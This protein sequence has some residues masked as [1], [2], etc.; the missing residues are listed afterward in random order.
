[1]A[2]T[3]IFFLGATLHA[4][5]TIR[6]LLCLKWARRLPSLKLSAKQPRPKC[7]I[8]FAARDEGARVEQTLRHILALEGVDFEVIPIDDRSR[9]ETSQI[10][11]RIS[12]EDPRVKPKRV[13]VLPENWLGKCHACHLGAQSASGDWLLFTDADCWL[14]P[15]VLTRALALAEAEKSSM[16][17]SH[18]AL[19][20]AHY[21]RKDAT[22]LFFSA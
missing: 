10:L 3:V 20:P 5:F 13:D 21:P 19:L 2:L 8:I 16:S 15:D 18:P 1:V 14:K 7:S 6:T 4:V 12:S 17:R 11:K 9:D 22:L